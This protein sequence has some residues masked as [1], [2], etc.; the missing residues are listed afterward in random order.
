MP[1][2]PP[3]YL[4]I[5]LRYIY[6]GKVDLTLQSLDT[7]NL[8]IIVKVF[9]I[10]SLTSCVQDHL[11][12]HQ[13]EF[14]QQ[15]EI[16]LKNGEEYDV[17]I[18]VGQNENFREVHA[19][20]AILLTR[21]QYF[22]TELSKENIERKDGKFILRKADLLPYYLTLILKYIYCE[23]IDLTELHGS[24]V[25]ELLK[26][27][28]LF[29]IQS[30]ILQI[31]RHLIQHQYEILQQ[32][33]VEILESTYQNELLSEICDGC[34]ETICVDPGILFDSDKFISLEA[35]I[36]ELLL[37]RDDLSTYEI[38]IWEILMKWGLA[39]HSDIPQDVTKWNKEQI[40]IMERT[41]HKYIPLIRFYD[42][43][44]EDFFY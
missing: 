40:T 42:I 10:Q 31:K 18:Y 29:N 4:T 26:I 11:T 44:S 7:L 39:Q 3:R 12:K 5:I 27:V 23:K 21:S 8:L 24:V 34:L 14:L 28:K 25:L 35:P 36:M 43:S 30:L 22:H 33:P 37:K 16:L 20:S 38:D 15:N 2:I 32:N 6:C 13:K 1:D 17:I 19:H 9:N 41:L